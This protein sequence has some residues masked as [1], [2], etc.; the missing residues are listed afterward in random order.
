MSERFLKYS[1]YLKQKYGQKVYKLP[2]NLDLTCPNRDDNLSE[3]GC[4]FCSEIGT[5]FENVDNSL[6][7]KNQLLEN[8][9]VIGK[10]YNADKFIAYFQNFTNT[11]MPI[12]KFKKVIKE[13]SIKDILKTSISTR[14]DCIS[15][16]YLKVLKDIA[17]NNNINISIEL[18]LQSMKYT[19]L[20]KV[21]RGHSLAEFID[22]VLRIKRF[23]FNITVHLIA[24]L[25][26]DSKDDLVETAKVMSALDIDQIKLHSLYILKGT[27]LGKEYKNNEFEICSMKDYIERIVEFIRYTKEDIVFQRFLARA[28]KDK[29]LF[30]NWGRSWWKINNLILKKLDEENIFQGDKCNYLN[31]KALNKFD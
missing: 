19:T 12:D 26:W 9:E 20:E 16:K 14:P 1:I 6:S 25:P 11:Y 21:N 28:P 3:G 31:G 2:V 8:K 29:A 23:N 22:A 24:N 10:K 13:S 18:G 15:D 30:C 17:K 5:G 27:K 4:S 7:V